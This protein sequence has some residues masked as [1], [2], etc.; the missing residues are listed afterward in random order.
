MLARKRSSATAKNA[1]PI[2][3]IAASEPYTA[4]S[5][6]PR[7]SAAVAKL[8]KWAVGSRR[9]THCNAAGMLSRGVSSAR[10]P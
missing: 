4:S 8:T 9:M 5:P 6:A 7:C 10:I 1:P 3:T 2:A